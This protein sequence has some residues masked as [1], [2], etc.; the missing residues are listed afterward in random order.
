MPVLIPRAEIDAVM[1]RY[2]DSWAGRN[3][4]P[5][6]AVREVTLSY[7]NNATHV[8][9]MADEEAARLLAEAD[10]LDALA[11]RYEREAA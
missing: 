10:A 3:D 5:A 9:P 8:R 6:A 2:G 7:R 11:D 4:L 1:E